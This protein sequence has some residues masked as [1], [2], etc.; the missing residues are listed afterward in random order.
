MKELVEYTW[1]AIRFEPKDNIPAML[2]WGTINTV[3]RA[4]AV[5][6]AI[7]LV[8]TAVAHGAFF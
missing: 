1:L 2:F 8:L 5:Y 6:L 3:I 4:G 7:R